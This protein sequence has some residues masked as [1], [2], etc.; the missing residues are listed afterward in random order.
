MTA[1]IV[2]I[3]ISVNVVERIQDESQI[4]EL[5][6][7]DEFV[8][9]DCHL[10]EQQDHDQHVFAFVSVPSFVA[11]ISYNSCAPIYMIKVKEKGVAKEAMNDRHGHSI[12]PGENYL[13]GN[14]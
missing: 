12:G 11:V 8:D 7:Q 14:Y 3:L 10:D 5:E 2:W 1:I 6:E 9:G 4:N 13:K